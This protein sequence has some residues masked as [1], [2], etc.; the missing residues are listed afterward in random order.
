M[1]DIFQGTLYC[2]IFHGEQFLGSRLWPRI[3]ISFV[4]ELERFLCVASEMAW[5][6]WYSLA[7]HIL[8]Y[9]QHQETW[10]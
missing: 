5:R 6:F 1:V 8:K 10:E 4:A 2:D 3:R 9:L 7:P